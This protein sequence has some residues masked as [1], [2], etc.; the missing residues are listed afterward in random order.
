M[1]HGVTED[2]VHEL[3]K[4]INASISEFFDERVSPDSQNYTD[5]YMRILA[6]FREN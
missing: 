3:L 1:S 4:L 6:G 2:E 5:H